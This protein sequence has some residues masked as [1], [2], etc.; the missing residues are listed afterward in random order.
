MDSQQSFARSR[1]LE[2]KNTF[3]FVIYVHSTIPLMGCFAHNLHTATSA[4]GSACS[5]LCSQLAKSYMAFNFSSFDLP[6]VLSEKNALQ[7]LLQSESVSFLLHLWQLCYVSRGSWLG[8]LSFPAQSHCVGSWKGRKV[9]SLR[10][11]LHCKHVERHW[12]LLSMF[13]AG[14]SQ[15][16]DKWKVNEW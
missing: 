2:K 15:N 6:S 4:D 12:C 8:L 10:L 13:Q 14:I 1:I 3:T 9:C 7:L 11:I 16:V 5:L